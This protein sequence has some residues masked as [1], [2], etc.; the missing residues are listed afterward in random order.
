MKRSE[1]I[2]VVLLLFVAAANCFA[3]DFR[4][5][6]TFEDAFDASCRVRVNG[7]RGSG[8]FIGAVGDNAYILTNYH[9]VTTN[10]TATLDFWTNGKL[11]SITGRI[12]WRSYDLNMPADFARIVV[13]AQ[14]LK[15]IN[16]PFIALGGADAKP[17]IGAFIVSSGAPDGRFTQAWKGQVLEYY[18][19]RTCV[20]TP[21]PVPGQSGSA[22]CEFVD[23]EL[24]VTGI[25]TWLLGEKG[26]DD[27][28]GGAIPISNLYQALQQRPE[29]ASFR[30]SSP[31]P[32]DATECAAPDIRVYEFYKTN[33]PACKRIASDVD[34]LVQTG[35]VEKISADY[36]S[37]KNLAEQYAV[38]ELPT[39]VVVVDGALKAT[40]TYD[41]LISRGVKS[42]ITETVEAIKEQIVRDNEKKQGPEIPQPSVEESGNEL[43]LSFSVGQQEQT[44]SP[45]PVTPPTS[46]NITDF[47]ERPAV[48]ETPYDTGIFADSEQ[49][50][51]N[52]GKKN[53][54]VPRVEPNEEQPE[55]PQERRGLFGGNIKRGIEGI[56][57]EAEERILKAVENLISEHADKAKAFWKHVKIKLYA[58]ILFLVVV[59]VLIAETIKALVV[60]A[61]RKSKNV[62]NCAV[63]T[64]AERMKDNS[65]T[66]NERTKR[67]A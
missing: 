56:T 51:K 65:E 39:V 61:F 20:F 47:R 35:L 8:T 25:L 46:R 17:N 22:I 34:A 26:R 6:E 18:N 60:G 33:C 66:K 36:D 52:R 57:D 63:I 13:S 62:W 41:Q 67:D 16:P 40:I 37:G 31:V 21:P 27:S 32:P 55:Q 4:R 9:V 19:A 24:F 44:L 15:K 23:G 38:T 3:V 7:A 10:Q 58:T 5:A 2:P 28:K 49:L 50:W 64:A 30:E 42:T 43:N 12:D 54:P 59:G 1:I 48:Y 14:E 11:E 45:T 29:P 53:N